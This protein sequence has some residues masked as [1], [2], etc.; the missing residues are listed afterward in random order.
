[1]IS[2]QSDDH[3]GSS[4]VESSPPDVDGSTT[5]STSGKKQPFHTT[6]KNPL[7]SIL[8]QGSKIVSGALNALD[9]RDVV[10]RELQM[11]DTEDAVWSTIEQR[12]RSSTSSPQ[13]HP[14]R[15]TQFMGGRTA[16]SA[17]SS[18]LRDYHNHDIRGYY[19]AQELLRESESS[20]RSNDSRSSS[21]LNRFAAELSYGS[22]RGGR[23]PE[24]LP[25]LSE[26]SELLPSDVEAADT[27]T[28]TSAGSASS[29]AFNSM[30]GLCK[31][32]MWMIL[33]WFNPK[34]IT[35][36]LFRILLHSTLWIALIL[37]AMAWV[38]FYEFGNP[39]WDAIPV[40]GV[41]LS[42][43]CN[44]IG[45]Q[46]LMMELAR[47]C[48]YV[49]IEVIVLSTKFGK[50]FVSPLFRFTL[51]QARGY[52]F[53]LA[54]WGLWDFILLH[55]DDPFQQNW[56]YWTPLTIYSSANPG[57]YM[58]HSEW[59]ERILSS[60]IV[61]GV[62]TTAKRVF[63]R[64]S[65]GKRNVAAYKP[66]L[67]RV[68]N[69]I[70]IIAEVADLTR[71]ADSS[72]STNVG[73]V[74]SSAPKDRASSNIKWR[75]IKFND[76]A[77]SHRLSSSS[78]DGRPELGQDVNPNDSVHMEDEPISSSSSTTD[79]RPKLKRELSQMKSQL[80]PWD[81]SQI[82]DKLANQVSPTL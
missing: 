57:G 37:F 1:M 71:K 26:A 48:Q 61:V 31:R 27:T 69:E 21:G 23:N 14:R 13:Q 28:G 67:E 42:R 73:I 70:V 64:M 35:V 32:C 25:L 44:F 62:A 16:S 17:T 63:V 74:P 34:R 22:H 49:F 4:T 29:T 24:E 45:R 77:V 3:T 46:L 55:G 51:V 78:G 9:P 12:T 10:K 72:R 47:F 53:V 56:L 2:R 40:E 30:T 15:W 80:D 60:A 41:T 7:K 19:R 43:W 76:D 82:T 81:V 50:T 79:P 75:S 65:F 52:P 5:T 54:I 18:G 11:E 66:S 33:C 8:G 68:L 20:I 58:I 39:S 6:Q 38:L 36:G 59:Y